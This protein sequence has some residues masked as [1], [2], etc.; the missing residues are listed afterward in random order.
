MK[1]VNTTKKRKELTQKG[2]DIITL[3][4]TEDENIDQL[5]KE[6]EE[7]KMLARENEAINMISEINFMNSIRFNNLSRVA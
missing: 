3:S 5:L 4:F 2:D 7:D 6:Q 1:P